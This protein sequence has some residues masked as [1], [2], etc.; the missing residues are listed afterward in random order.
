MQRFALALLAVLTVVLTAAT[1]GIAASD[2]AAALD[3]DVKAAYEKYRGGLLP[4]FSHDTVGVLGPFFWGRSIDMGED[5]RF[6]DDAGRPDSNGTHLW[7]YSFAR[8]PLKHARAEAPPFYR[9]GLHGRNNLTARDQDLAFAVQP[10]HMLLNTDGAHNLKIAIGYIEDDFLFE[11]GDNAD[12]EHL[13]LCDR[14]IVFLPV[15]HSGGKDLDK[16]DQSIYHVSPHYAA[17]SPCVIEFKAGEII[18]YDWFRNPKNLHERILYDLVPHFDGDNLLRPGVTHPIVQFD[19]REQGRWVLKIERD[20]RDGLAGGE[21][22]DH[23]DLVITDRSDGAK[24]YSV[25]VKPDA[26]R[27]A[28]SIFS[29]GGGPADT[30]ELLLG[31]QPYS[32]ATGKAVTFP[33][34]SPRIRTMSID[35]VEKFRK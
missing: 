1:V 33:E 26:S 13:A 19:I 20:G 8:F 25:D 10:K 29:P 9:H 23:Y 32:R 34:R 11:H 12:L 7:L 35:K 4:D 3:D 2:T 18:S 30:S 5:A 15:R 14:V 31:L 21:V 27:W 24:P 17:Q 16:T 28:L 22:D 6:A